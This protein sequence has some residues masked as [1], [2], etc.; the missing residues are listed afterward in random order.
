MPMLF[1]DDSN[2]FL[3]GNSLKDIEQKIKSELAEIAEWLK[4]NK[5]TLNVDKTLCMVFINRHIEN[6]VGIKLDGRLINRVTETQ[7]LGVMID[8]K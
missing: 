7:F 5:L 6:E 1:A 2:L 3:N 8:D 4:L